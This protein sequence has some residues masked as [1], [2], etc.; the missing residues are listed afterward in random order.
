MD[1]ANPLCTAG[2][3]SGGEGELISM[4]GSILGIGTDIGGSV[5]ILAMC[6]GLFCI[7]RSAQRVPYARQAGSTEPGL[8]LAKIKSIAGTI[9]GSL[10]DYELFMKFI[11]DTCGGVTWLTHAGGSHDRKNAFP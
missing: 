2:G 7:K 9:A 10:R 8:E 6:N 3:S 4:D 11:V 1:P 5:H